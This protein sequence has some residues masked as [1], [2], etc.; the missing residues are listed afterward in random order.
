MK[1]YKESK[2]NQSMNYLGEL[3][4]IDNTWRIFHQALQKRAKLPSV[5]SYQVAH[6]NQHYLE[7]AK[8]VI[9]KE[10]QKQSGIQARLNSELRKSIKRV[11]LNTI[12][13]KLLCDPTI[14]D[15]VQ[16]LGL[17][18]YGK[19]ISTFPWEEFK[20][21]RHENDRHSNM[22]LTW[23]KRI[24]LGL[25]VHLYFFNNSLVEPKLYHSFWETFYAPEILMDFTEPLYER[26]IYDK[27][28]FNR[29]HVKQAQAFPLRERIVSSKRLEYLLDQ[30]QTFIKV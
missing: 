11:N 2:P 5:L 7:T 27:K 6:I 28:Q 1:R 16:F 14:E 22:P 10:Y 18:E 26:D 24:D 3:G 4:A 20:G 17:I 13:D 23:S 19:D 9:R 30:N 29:Y 12:K 15:P 21:D 8:G 25:H